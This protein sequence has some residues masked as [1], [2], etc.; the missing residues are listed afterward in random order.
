MSGQKHYLSDTLKHNVNNLC[1]PQKYTRSYFSWDNTTST[2]KP[3]WLRFRERKEKKKQFRITG[4]RNL[5]FLK[6]IV[7]YNF[8]LLAHDLMDIILASGR[9]TL[10]SRPQR[11]KVELPQNKKSDS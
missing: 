9:D 8:F 2:F 11:F 1:L 7:T 4:D 3:K 5:D 10:N 6:S